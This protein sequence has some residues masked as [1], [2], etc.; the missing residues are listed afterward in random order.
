MI[1]AAA[2]T[3]PLSLAAALAVAGPAAAHSTDEYYYLMIGPGGVPCAGT[4]GFMPMP[5]PGMPGL[6]MMGPGMM[7]P[8]G[9]MMTGPTMDMGQTSA[10][11]R[12][13][14]VK[15]NLERWLAWNGNPRLK[16]G[17]LSE[18]DANTFSAEIV[19]VDGSL[20]ETLEIDRRT[21]AMRPIR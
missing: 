1:R 7:G 18:K 14:D 11:L 13:A 2:L 9:G 19:T 5:G 3:L 4:M 12:L 20:V 10:P 8:Y 21:G 17:N 16:L 15:S 6:G